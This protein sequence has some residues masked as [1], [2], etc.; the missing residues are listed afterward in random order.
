MGIE[1]LG[2]AVTNCYIQYGTSYQAPWGYDRMSIKYVYGAPPGHP[3]FGGGE[4]SMTVSEI[5][6]APNKKIMLGDW[7]YHVDRQV[8]DEKSIW[9]NYK[10]KSTVVILWGDVHSQIYRFPVYD[11]T[12]AQLDQLVWPAPSPINGYW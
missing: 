12:H 10:G 3:N 11:M 2:F 4:K 9:H 6:K 8:F 7:I 1:N 5:S